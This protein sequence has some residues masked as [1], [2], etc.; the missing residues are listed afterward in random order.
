MYLL[1]AVIFVGLVSSAQ[2]QVTPSDQQRALR[3]LEQNQQ[4]QENFLKNLED[5]QEQEI[6]EKKKPKVEV[7]K[8]EAKEI[9]GGPCFDIKTIELKGA[10]ILKGKELDKITKPYVDTC[11]GIGEINKLMRDITNYYVDNGYVTTRVAVPQQDMK[12]GNLQLLVIEGTVEDVILN[13]NT[14]RDKAQ[15]AMAF[16]FMKGKVL[17]LRDIEQGL[18]QLNRLSS[19][20]ATMQLVPGDKQGGTKV[21]ITNKPNKQNRGSIGYDNSGQNS[22]GKNKA[23]ASLERD[24]MLGLGDAWSFNYN[25][26]T[27]SHGGEKGS[28]VYAGNFSLPFGYWTFSQNASHSEYNVTNQLVGGVLPAS[29]QTDTSQTRLDRVIYRNQDSKLSLNTGLKLKDIKA[30][31]DNSPN[32]SQTYNLS[33]W[34]AGT[35]LHYAPSVQS[36]ALELAFSMGLMNL[37]QN[38]ILIIWQPIAR[39]HSLINILWMPVFINLS[40]SQNRIY[41][42]EL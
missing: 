25:E 41:P 19:S 34:T 29:G 7:Q 2:A 16:P 24:N 31:S 13:E 20:A 40:F 21:V 5:K 37:V 30:F 27:A 36:G 11:M 6:R 23:T 26:D 10:T 9:T 15:V 3:S 38:T 28:E 35:D 17:N 33:I 32:V 12:S 42:G 4:K 18:D 22:T 14:L 39:L 8:P 1:I